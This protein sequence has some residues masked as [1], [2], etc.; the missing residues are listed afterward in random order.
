MQAAIRTDADRK[1]L[2]FAMR[3]SLG[4]GLLMF[5]MKVGAYLL[6]GSA[7]ILSDAA[8]SVVHVAAV[9]FATYS[10]KLSYRPPDENHL[11]GHTKI[12][13]FS[14][15]FEGAMII[16]AAIYIIYESIHKW[17]GGL[18]L[19]NLGYGTSLTAAAAAINGSLGA[20]LIWL[21]K[22]KNSL[23]LTANGKHVLTDCW[24]SLAV[25][26]GLGLVLV[27]KWLPFD[28]ICGI[29]MACNILYSGGALVK[30]GWTGLMDTADPAVQKQL[31]E[32]LDRE[33]SKHGITY[34]QLRHR[35]LGDSHW[36]DV[37]LVFPD[38]ISLAV[39]HRTATEI[40]GAVEASLEPHAAMTTHLES[41]SDHDDVHL[42]GHARASTSEGGP[43]LS[44]PG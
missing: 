11:Y 41:A 17:L 40:E 7:A 31:I 34:H 8:E 21:G 37:H 42:H 19:E 22:R 28:P 25:L 36:V 12:A 13:F 29:L 30:S 38:K 16:L 1:A 5:V 39:A 20:Y 2:T 14:A 24:T 32:L 27:T 35:N 4:V 3:L 9:A 26:V 44:K 33:T 10:L 15:G 6:T 23:I 18:H 43:S